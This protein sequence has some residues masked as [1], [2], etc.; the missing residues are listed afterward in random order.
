MAS[1]GLRDLHLDQASQ[2]LPGQVSLLA[3]G[4]EALM[5]VQ[6]DRN[7][8]LHEIRIKGESGNACLDNN[9]RIA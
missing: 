7:P 5:E 9:I 2:S 8:F 1:N 3:E 6:L 4:N